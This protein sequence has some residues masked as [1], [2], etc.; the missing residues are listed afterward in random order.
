MKRFLIYPSVIAGNSL[1]SDGTPSRYPEGVYPKD[2]LVMEIDS[3]DYHKHLFT[4]SN[5]GDYF[6]TSAFKPILQNAQFPEISFLPLDI[7]VIGLNLEANHPDHGFDKDSFWKLEIAPNGQDFSTFKSYLIVSEKALDF[8]YYHDAFEDK[9][10]GTFVGPDFEM[11]MN[12]VLVEGD[13]E[14]FVFNELSTYLRATEKMR[15]KI[16]AE[17]RRR[18]GLPPL[19]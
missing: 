16:H 11:V 1:I 12:K 5:I 2:A 17:Y 10:P 4:T 18:Q 6:V 3:Y 8:L 9:N 7:L 14:D 15:E 13:I 19:Q